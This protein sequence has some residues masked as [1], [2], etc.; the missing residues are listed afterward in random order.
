[1]DSTVSQLAFLKDCQ[2]TVSGKQD[3][4][5]STAKIYLCAVPVQS[6]ITPCSAGTFFGW[7]RLV[8][9]TARFPVPFPDASRN[10]ITHESTAQCHVP[11]PMHQLVGG[12]GVHVSSDLDFKESDSAGRE[13]LINLDHEASPN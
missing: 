2:V 11:F 10:I 7:F 9:S 5:A 12:V 8:Q 13:G 4:P 1:M 3:C 6:N